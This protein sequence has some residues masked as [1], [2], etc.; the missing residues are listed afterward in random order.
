[1]LKIAYQ[2]ET[3]YSLYAELFPWSRVLTAKDVPG[4]K[5]S[6]TVAIVFID[7]ESRRA[8][9]AARFEVLAMI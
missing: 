7:A 6:V 4:K 2:S 1:M 9:S 5:T 3:Q 8:S